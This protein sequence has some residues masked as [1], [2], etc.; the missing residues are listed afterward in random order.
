MKTPHRPT[1]WILA[2][3]IISGCNGGNDNATPEPPEAAAVSPAPAPPPPPP[4]PPPRQPAVVGVGREGRDYGSGPIS[5]PVA[6]Y[7]STRQRLV[8]DVEIASA[9]KLYKA[10]NGHFPRSHEEFMEKI[11]RA[12]RIQL[13]AIPSNERYV[14]DAQKAAATSSYD[15]RDPPLFVEVIQ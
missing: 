11:I 12:N 13:P 14:Y 3:A 7:F 10:V 1:L 9:M 8:F 2:M 4:P 5:T 6:A 15:P